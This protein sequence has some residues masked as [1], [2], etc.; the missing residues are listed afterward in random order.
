MNDLKDLLGLALDDGPAAAHAGAADDVERGRRLLRRRNR[1]RLLG[2]GAAVA[3][4]AVAGAVVPALTGGPNARPA[5]SAS[6][7][8]RPATTAGVP[9][10]PAASASQPAV[11]GIRLVD[12][13]GAQPPG[14]VVK[15][16]PNHWVIQGSTPFALTIA[17]PNAA[18][19]NP[20]F[21]L[22]KL[23]VTQ[24]SFDTSDAPGWTPAHAPGHE[25]YYSVKGNTA[26]LVIEQAAG[27]WLVVQAPTSLHWTEQQL[28]QFGLG[29]SILPTAQEGQG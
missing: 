9:K 16:I 28:V 24:E 17:P 8:A 3:A 23:V 11:T 6:L 2:A 4:V 18:N 5:A 19:K 21:F 25:A 20:D 13:T 14:Y 29:V 12:Y 1:G 22:G 26:S 10:T 7:P 27:R 15:V